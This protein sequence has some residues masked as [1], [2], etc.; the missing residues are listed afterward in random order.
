MAIGT[1]LAGC[2]TPY[3]NMGWMG[4]VAAQQMTADTYR[5][6]SR[7]NAY[8]GAATIQDYML[9]KAAETTKATG[10]T[11]FVVI[12]SADVTRTSIG[13]TPGS[14][15][16]SFIGSTAFSTYTPGVTYQIAKPG[17]DAYIRVLTIKRGE[18]APPGA[19]P[20]DEIIT[21]IG[22]RVKRPLR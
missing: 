10:G 13:Q 4:G 11:H 19:F 2:V 17:E 9:L 16:T 18:A 14:V 15:T 6:S 22:Q 5:I 8:T 21:F 3:Q 1:L 20:A 7:G 12:S